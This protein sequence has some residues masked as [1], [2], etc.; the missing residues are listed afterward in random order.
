MLI[1]EYVENVIKQFKS[2][3]TSGQSYQENIKSLIEHYAPD[4][5]IT[6]GLAKKVYG[7]PNFIIKKRN[8]PIGYVA[9]LHIDKPL[10]NQE[11]I[12]ELDLCKKSLANLMIT[13]YLEFRLYNEGVLISSASIAEI[14]YGKIIP[15][16]GDFQNAEALIMEFCDYEKNTIRSL[17]VLSTMMAKIARLFTCIIEDVMI[18]D[19]REKKHQKEKVLKKSLTEQLEAFDCVLQHNIST[20]EFANIYSQTITFGMLA[21]RLYGGP[22]QQ[23]FSRQHAAELLPSSYALMKDLFQYL[24]GQNLDNR[25]SWII[26]ELAEILK[27]TDF[28]GLLD[29]FKKPVSENL[30]VKHF[31]EIFLKEYNPELLEKLTKSHK[32]EPIVAFLTEAV[33]RCIS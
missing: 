19:E 16:S 4:V 18:L 29:D 24:A 28:V 26:D 1:Q 8:K 12:E 5:S 27:T 15:R 32:P 7:T 13:N 10:D 2:G 17:S 31:Y 33:Q 20:G 25:I 9:I 6:N 11:R 21:A 14:Q 23:E 22:A 30:S 3:I